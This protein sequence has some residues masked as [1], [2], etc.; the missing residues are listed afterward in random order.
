MKEVEEMVKENEKV[1]EDEMMMNLE[2][3]TAPMV[4]SLLSNMY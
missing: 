2:P 3:P 1:V 4:I